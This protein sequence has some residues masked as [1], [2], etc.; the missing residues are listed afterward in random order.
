[1]YTLEVGP[2]R[3]YCQHYLCDR[4]FDSLV[5][6]AAAGC[7]VASQSDAAVEDEPHLA[8]LEHTAVKEVAHEEE[9][10]T[11]VVVASHLGL[12]HYSRTACFV[13]HTA[14]AEFR[15]AAAAAAAAE[16]SFAQ[17]ADDVASCDYCILQAEV[18]NLLDGR[19]KVVEWHKTVAE[20]EQ[21]GGEVQTDSD[22]VP[23][24]VANGK[25]T[26]RKS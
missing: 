8:E 23:V 9:E 1:M 21:I 5:A 10:W 22:P 26:V 25:G 3:W 12:G 20:A 17:T 19:K 16:E 15:S 11:A 7:L 24:Y 14:E 18:D 6:T 13:G 2:R 4:L